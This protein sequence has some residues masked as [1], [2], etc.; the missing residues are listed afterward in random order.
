ILA[1]TRAIRNQWIQRFCE[2][3]LQSDTGQWEAHVGNC[4]L[5]VTQTIAGRQ[6]ILKARVKSLAAQLDEKVLQVSK[7]R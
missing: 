4:E 5:I 3:F 6:L 1:P 7:W 2:L